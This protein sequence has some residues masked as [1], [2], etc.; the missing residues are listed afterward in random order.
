MGSHLSLTC[1]E[2]TKSSVFSRF[3]LSV[4]IFPLSIIINNDYRYILYSRLI[5]DASTEDGSESIWVAIGKFKYTI[6]RA[7]RL[8]IE[9]Q[10]ARD[11]V[12]LQ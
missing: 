12:V 9:T 2:G 4:S 7:L 10:C 8:T 3:A 5:A 1:S 11:F 6:T